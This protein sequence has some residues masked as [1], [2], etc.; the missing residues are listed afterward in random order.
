MIFHVVAIREISEKNYTMIDVLCFWITEEEIKDI[1][2]EY[3]LITLELYPINKDK[4]KEFWKIGVLINYKWKEIQLLSNA[5]D[6][7]WLAYGLCII[8]FNIEYINFIDERKA[9]QMTVA[10][11]ITL[12]RRDAKKRISQQEALKEAQEKQDEKIFNDEKLEKILVLVDILLKKI[13][14]FIKKVGDSLPKK[15]LDVLLEQWQE[16]SKLKMWR[17]LEMLSL[18]LW[19]AY[20]NY[21]NLE[22]EYL[23]TKSAVDT[24][25][26]WSEEAS[27]IRFVTSEIQKLER[28]KNMLK[29]WWTTWWAD[30]LYANFWTLLVYF[31][32]LK[33]DIKTQ[34][35]DFCKDSSEFFDYL[36]LWFI[37]LLVMSSFYFA[38]SD[39]IKIKDMNE[40]VYVMFVNFWVFWFIVH[41]LNHIRKKELLPNT[42]ILICW[43]VVSILCIWV[44]KQSFIF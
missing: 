38:F 24:N 1:L 41:L 22:Q 7:E 14:V 10:K 6:L 37:M 26:E 15:D 9:S 36:A 18:L 4:A 2:H 20:N 25:I 8:W 44:L 27:N 21:N 23:A 33:R 17:N 29:I 31:K 43:V 28:A 32:L 11:V 13:P 16:L 19:K 42:M 3:K 40:Y 35:K 12:A 39:I 5:T 34:F 30:M